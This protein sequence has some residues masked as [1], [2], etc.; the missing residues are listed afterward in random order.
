MFRLTEVLHGSTVFYFSAMV[1]LT[2]VS[3]A[4]ANGLIL[5]NGS[6][7]TIGAVTSSFSINNPTA[8]PS[9]TATPSGNQILD[10]LIVPSDVT[11][12]CGP[13]AFGGGMTFWVEPG[14]SPDGGNFVA[15]DGDSNY[16][17][18]LSQT[19]NG[20]IIGMKYRT[21]FYQ[22]AVQQSGFT[23]ATTERWQ[24]S[25]GGSTQLSSLMNNASHGDV[26]WMSQMLTFTATATTEVFRFLAVGTPNGEPPFVLLDGVTFTEAPEP[27]TD[28]LIGVGLLGIA[29]ARRLLKRRA[30]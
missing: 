14:P 26:G 3:R 19:L 5:V 21:T 1:L 12:L 15:V 11:N 24:V 13:T 23:G 9:W 17:T 20:L 18:P 27:R 4:Q 30:Q 6:F 28:T 8:L 10:C 29:I 7:E 25:L 16:A 2:C 22:A